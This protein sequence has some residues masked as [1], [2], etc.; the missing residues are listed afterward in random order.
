MFS[1]FTCFIPQH[2]CKARTLP[3]AATSNVLYNLTTTP[4]FHKR[5]VLIHMPAVIKVKGAPINMQFLKYTNM[6]GTK[7]TRV[8]LDCK[9]KGAIS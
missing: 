6:Q 3:G 7:E 1:V 8:I 9:G 5:Y 2:F 4:I